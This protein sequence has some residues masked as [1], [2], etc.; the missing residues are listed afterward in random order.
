MPEKLLWQR[1]RAGRL[2]GLRFRR[3]HP[4][5]P[6]VVD[7]YCH[8]ARV[9]VEVDG[10]SHLGRED[11]DARR[12]EYLTRLGLRVIHVLNDDVIRAP[13]YVAEGIAREMGLDP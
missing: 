4:I 5:G 9:I 10:L 2:M 1:L 7:F 6:Y 11:D 8:A 3:Q 13:D 12:E